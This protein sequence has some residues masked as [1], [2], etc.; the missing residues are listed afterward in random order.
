M[1]TEFDSLMYQTMQLRLTARSD[2]PEFPADVRMKT[3]VLLETAER[4]LKAARRAYLQVMR[5]HR[6]NADRRKR[7]PA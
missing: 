7:I 5:I 2:D 6:S 3:G 1:S 4:N